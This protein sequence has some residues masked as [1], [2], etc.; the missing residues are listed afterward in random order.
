MD[1]VEIFLKKALSRISRLIENAAGNQ[2]LEAIKSVIYQK[3]FINITLEILALCSLYTFS[4]AMY[5]SQKFIVIENILLVMSYISAYYFLPKRSFEYKSM[6]TCLSALVMA[7]PALIFLHASADLVAIYGFLMLSII[8]LWTFFQV[9][10]DNSKKIPVMV[11]DEVGTSYE[12]IKELN[13]KFVVK[14]I[15]TSQYM[16]EE[17]NVFENLNDA[18][19][20]LENTKILPFFKNPSQIIYFHNSDLA[21]AMNVLQIASEY[22][23]AVFDGDHKPLQISS[24]MKKSSLTGDEI[25]DFKSIFARSNIVIEY[26]G[27]QIMKAF[28]GELANVKSS[29]IIVTC[30][31]D[32]LVADLIAFKDRI[33]FYISPIV[34][35]INNQEKVDYV[36]ASICSF[37]TCF[38]SS[39]AYNARHYVDVIKTCSKKSVKGV[40]LISNNDSLYAS[41]LSGLSQRLAELYA[42]N[43]SVSSDM[44]IIPIRF[45]RTIFDPSLF[46]DQI[47]MKLSDSDDIEIDNNTYY[48]DHIAA[49]DTFIRFLNHLSTKKNITGGRVYSIN[50]DNTIN[51]HLIADFIAHKNNVKIKINNISNDTERINEL[52]QDTQISGVSYTDFISGHQYDMSEIDEIEND[53][54]VLY[55]IVNRKINPFSPNF[56]REVI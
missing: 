2:R 15:I 28:I 40:Y 1:D 22:G 24:F 30:S 51:L 14:S 34:N 13:E 47:N 16:F 46:I 33:K 45:P 17:Y 53:K 3:S 48:V 9:D 49:C 21:S 8:V 27:N 35:V 54:N 41:N 5:S 55:S 36:F 25:S 11:I 42:Q 10:R 50:L 19:N 56:E 20:W 39:A 37:S 6:L 26:T 12:R 29:N 32:R 38:I 31:N 44:R 18:K 7:S 43:E 23:L 52:L 4:I